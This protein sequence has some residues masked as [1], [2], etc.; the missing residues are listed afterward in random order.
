MK[1]NI[2]FQD[3]SDDELP[4]SIFHQEDDDLAHVISLSLQVLDFFLNPI[5]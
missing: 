1:K 4:Q 3:F 2:S 5:L